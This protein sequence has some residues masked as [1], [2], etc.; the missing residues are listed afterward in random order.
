MYQQQQPR[1]TNDSPQ[2]VQPVTHQQAQQQMQGHF[3]LNTNQQY[4]QCIPQLFVSQNVQPMF[5][6]QNGVPV[7]AT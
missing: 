2:N 1:Q 6:I 3:M 7:P 4:Q 5:I